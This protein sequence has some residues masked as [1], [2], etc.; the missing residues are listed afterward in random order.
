VV[1][2]IVLWHPEQLPT[3][4]AAPAAEC[5]GL[6]VFCQ[7]VKWHPEFPQSFSAIVKL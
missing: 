2:E 5:A 1:Q 4:K 3:A 6:L 7:V